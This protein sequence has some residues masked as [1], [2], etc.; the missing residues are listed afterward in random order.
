MASFGDILKVFGEIVIDEKVAEIQL[1]AA[2]P[3][4]DVTVDLPA[5]GQLEWAD[6]AHHYKVKALV[7]EKVK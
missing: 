7:V 2:A 3:G 5:T 4:D 1:H 6:G